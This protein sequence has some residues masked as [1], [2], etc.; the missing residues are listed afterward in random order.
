MQ[1][2]LK[3]FTPRSR[4]THTTGNKAWPRADGGAL[5]ESTARSCMELD[6]LVPFYVKGHKLLRYPGRRV[7]GSA[8][9]AK[10][11]TRA[12]QSTRQLDRFYPPAR[13]A[14]APGRGW[15][16]ADEQARCHHSLLRIATRR[17]A[18]SSGGTTK[19]TYP[20]SGICA[21]HGPR[22]LRASSTRGSPAGARRPGLGH[23]LVAAWAWVRAACGDG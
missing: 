6:T 2:T 14:R 15:L 17:P 21:R 8:F 4:S 19:A 11:V 9:P 16:K 18:G 10:L 20:P 3:P 7:S 23:M 5:H 22:G 1:K 12:M 13:P